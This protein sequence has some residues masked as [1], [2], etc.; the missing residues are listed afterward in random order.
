MNFKIPNLREYRYRIIFSFVF[1]II[2]I[3]ILLIGF[4]K[5]LFLV[6]C[7]LVG[8]LVGLA[9]DKNFILEVIE[10]IKEIFYI[11]RE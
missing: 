11:G 8:Y 9:I 6:F 1:L 10:K 7:F 2:G 4:W 5:T 3:L